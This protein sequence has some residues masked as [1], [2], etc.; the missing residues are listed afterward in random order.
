[1]T[2]RTSRYKQEKQVQARKHTNP[3]TGRLDMTSENVSHSSSWCFLF[4]SAFPCCHVV[5]LRF[6]RPHLVAQ[7]YFKFELSISSKL[8]K[9]CVK[10]DPTFSGKSSRTEQLDSRV[11]FLFSLSWPPN[12]RQLIH[13]VGQKR[14]GRVGGGDGEFRRFMSPHRDFCKP[15]CDGG[16]QSERT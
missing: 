10:F 7:N 3:Q 6:S 15:I 14:E 11:K 12:S 16:L 5:S 13:L 4:P 1:M 2:Q 8:S 9:I